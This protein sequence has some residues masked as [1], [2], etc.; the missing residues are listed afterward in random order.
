MKLRNHLLLLLGLC[1]LWA[2]GRKEEGFVPKPRGYHHIDLPAHAYGA[3]PDSGAYKGYP[4]T[5]ELSKHAHLR[6]DTSYMTEP[7]WIEIYYPAFD[8]TVDISYKRLANMDSL[9]GY[10][11][12]SSKLT[13]KHNVRATA[14]D[15]QPIRTPQGDVGMLFDLEG[16]VPSQVQFYVTDSS[17]H[18]L[19]AA[20]YFP[21]SVKNDSL[22]P[23]IQYVRKDML[24]ML[25]TLKW[26]R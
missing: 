1:A 23:I 13:F 5:F 25:E 16:D 3:F 14:I 18:F 20:L 24:H 19:R 12:T 22:A 4:Y 17:R 26:K 8:A 7:Y 11:N 9:Q 10:V 21:T 6:P 2:C 15:E